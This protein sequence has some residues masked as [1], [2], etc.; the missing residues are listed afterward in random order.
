MPQR[1]KRTV[2]DLRRDNRARVLQR[3]YFEGPLSRQQLGEDTG[4]SSGAVSNVVGELLA[5]GL[6]EEA[7][8]VDSR[9]GR[10]IT[11]LK[12][13][14]SVG[15]LV[16]VDVGETRVRLELFDIAMTE[17]ARCDRRLDRDGFGPAQVVEQIAG[18]LAEVLRAG[19]ITRQELLGVGVGVP[20]IVER[21]ADGMGV[22]H[23]Q[24]TDW[25]DVPLERML[26]QAAELPPEVGCF[27][28]NG[29]HT[30]GRAEMWFG[31]GRGT[32]NAVIALIGSGVGACVVTD[33][34]LYG[35][36]RNSLGEWGHTTLQVRG[37]RCRCG[38]RGCLEAYVGADAMT[39]R[40]REAG[41]TPPDGAGEETALAALIAA[42]GGDGGQPRDPVAAALLRETAEFL[43]A[44]IADMVNLFCPERVLIGG[45][46]GLMV[47]PRLLEEVRGHARAYALRH[48]AGRG[49][50][51][52]GELGP[53]AV[54][55][56][57]ATLPLAH[58]LES[59]G[60]YEADRVAE[61]AEA[62]R[63]QSRVPLSVGAA[64]A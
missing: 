45:W 47:G 5:D 14:G 17:I 10:P 58:F 4:L 12:V 54:T 11:L 62:A 51:E 29:A 1:S 43:G 23:S 59:G 35:G 25:V 32:R 24:T 16:G 37:R 41:G 46:A 7:G 26:R 38:C 42:A 28:E 33:G 20:G 57:G 27:I 60:R 52:L 8:I 3:L 31:A 18:A 34:A 15:Y 19:G 50:I 13:A 49:T 30:L 48:P 56:G 6:V 9:G 22:V 63:E 36:G 61:P 55:M 2:R 44:A 40:W 53:N 64:S 39:A 21:D